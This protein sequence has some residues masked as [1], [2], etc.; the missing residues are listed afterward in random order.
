[1]LGE[2]AKVIEGLKK[3]VVLV[4]ETRPWRLYSIAGLHF[5]RKIPQ[6]ALPI[7]QRSLPEEL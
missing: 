7:V 5:M 2:D 6:A 3:V 4:Q 1:M